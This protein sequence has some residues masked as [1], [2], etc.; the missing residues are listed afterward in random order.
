MYIPP[1]ILPIFPFGLL[2]YLLVESCFTHCDSSC[3]QLKKSIKSFLCDKNCSGFLGSITGEKLR[4]V[5]FLPLQIVI[6]VERL[7]INDQVSQKNF[8]L[9]DLYQDLIPI[10]SQI[11]Q[12]WSKVNTTCDK[13]TL[14]IL[15]TLYF[16]TVS[17]LP[18]LF[19]SSCKTFFLFTFDINLFKTVFY[20]EE[21]C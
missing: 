4:T 12:Y 8:V 5:G 3:E 9:I 10:G 1:S 21:H 19:P 18:L 16:T 20:D 13:K 11:M 7:I 17:L 6:F 2:F 15:Y 14:Y